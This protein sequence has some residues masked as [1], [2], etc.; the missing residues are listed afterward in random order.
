VFSDPE[1]FPRQQLLKRFLA[2]K[3]AERKIIQ[4]KQRNSVFFAVGYLRA[5]F[6]HLDCLDY[7]TESERGQIDLFVGEIDS[8]IAIFDIEVQEIEHSSQDI[9]SEDID[10]DLLVVRMTIEREKQR[11]EFD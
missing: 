4:G 1:I 5:I 9:V 3:L 6:F 8:L 7:R 10:G 2:G 11:M